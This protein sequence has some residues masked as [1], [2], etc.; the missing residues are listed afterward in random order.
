MPCGAAERV[1]ER[2]SYACHDEGEFGRWLV[3]QAVVGGPTEN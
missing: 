1:G 2:M 3:E